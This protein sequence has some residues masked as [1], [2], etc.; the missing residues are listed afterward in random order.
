MLEPMQSNLVAFG[1]VARILGHESRRRGLRMPAFRSPPRAPGVVRAIRRWPDGGATVIVRIR[2]RP[3]GLVVADMVEGVLVANHV[4]GP[5]LVALR[6]D[7]IDAV[8]DG[9]SSAEASDA[10]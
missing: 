6:R 9:A 2:G 10:A 8:L 5:R 7:L 3:L 4:D 1:N